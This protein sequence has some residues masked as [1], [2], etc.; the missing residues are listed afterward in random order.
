M[1]KTVF[2]NHIFRKILVYTSAAMLFTTAPALSAL[3]AETNSQTSEQSAEA[4]AQQESQPISNAAPDAGTNAAQT[5]ADAVPAPDTPQT[6][7]DTVTVTPQP[8]TE[9]PGAFDITPVQNTVYAAS[10]KG[11]N[12]RSGPSTE[13]SKLGEPLRYG[14]EITV[15]GITNNNWYQ[16]QYSGS[17]GYVRA[18]LVS[19]IPPADSQNPAV[20]N[21]GSD[22]AGPPADENPD[23]TIPETPPADNPASDPA[24]ETQTEDSPAEEGYIEVPS[25]LLGTPVI[26]VLGV[27]IV[28]V[29]A[30]IAYSVYGLFRKET[31]AGEDYSEEEYYE[32]EPYPEE[33]YYED[34][35]YSGEEYYED[36]YYEDEPY[37]GDEYY[38]DEYY[39]DNNTK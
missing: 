28:G 9:Q 35:P 30:L 4:P 3:A 39:E 5:P 14:Q 29:M 12:V 24:G 18:D 6:P 19:A 26:I 20:E 32:D 17:V 11:L 22:A 1:N 7:T 21:P 27:A 16:I 23:T 13:Y 37:S 2:T 10:Q 25:R 34:E 8:G 15:T 31:V 33:E 38:E 36:A